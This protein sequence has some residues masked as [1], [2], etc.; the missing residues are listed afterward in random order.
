V[1]PISHP[2][3]K[4]GNYLASGI[5]HTESGAPTATGSI[6]AKM[7]E[8]RM[9]KLMPLKSRKDLFVHKGSASAPLALVS[10]GS[11]AGIV[12]EAF[13]LATRAGLRVKVL[14]PRL[15]FPVAEEV[16][17]GFFRSVQRGLVVEQSHQ[18]QLYRVI[19]MY[20]KVPD[21]L[22][23]FAKSG[24]NPFSPAE[25]VERLRAQARALLETPQEVNQVG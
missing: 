7:N 5:E 21:G 10:W 18:G 25:I 22:E 1:S 16:Y 2:G 12:L 20:A 15:L 19:R 14:V 3:M 8:K 13:D 23:S 6:H 11:T 17:D 9:R 24:S 4:G